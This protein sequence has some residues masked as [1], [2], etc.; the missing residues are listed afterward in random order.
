MGSHSLLGAIPTLATDATTLNAPHLSHLR[1]SI[2]SLA[3]KIGLVLALL[4]QP[5]T[6]ALV[7]VAAGDFSGHAAR[8]PCEVSSDI[9]LILHSTDWKQAPRK[10]KTK[11]DVPGSGL[12][13]QENPHPI[14]P[15]A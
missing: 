5:V 13:H 9:S 3:L 12:S 4:P 6:L 1:C 2:G 11:R 15:M 14:N 7:A 8:F 10:A